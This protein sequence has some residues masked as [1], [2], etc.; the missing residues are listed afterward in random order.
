SSVRDMAEEAQGLAVGFPGIERAGV[1]ETIM[2]HPLYHVTAKCIGVSD[3][4]IVL[5]QELPP[6]A[7]RCVKF[8]GLSG[9]PLFRVQPDEYSFAGI[10]FQGRGFADTVDQSASSPDIWVWAFPLSPSQLD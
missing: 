6:P 1:S 9:G 10:I 2:T 3:R 8:G 5:H 4:L 7:D